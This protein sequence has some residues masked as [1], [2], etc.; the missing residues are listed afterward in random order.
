L[1]WPLPCVL[2]CAPVVAVWPLFWPFV[3]PWVG[4]LPWLWLVLEPELGLLALV[5]PEVAAPL[6]AAPPVE[7]AEPCV[8]VG[9]LTEFWAVP[10]EITAVLLF[11]PVIPPSA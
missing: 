9:A 3:P 10:P 2:P 11:P 6:V 1:V 4:L 7:V 8:F 5:T